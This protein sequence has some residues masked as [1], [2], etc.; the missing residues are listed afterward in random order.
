MVPGFF[1][2]HHA[3][4]LAAARPAQAPHAAALPPAT[5]RPGESP[6]SGS[7]SLLPLPEGNRIVTVIE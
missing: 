2:E 3:A 5:L 1:R 4:T 6:E 7:S